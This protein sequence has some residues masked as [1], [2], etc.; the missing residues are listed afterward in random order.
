MMKVLR[1][2]PTEQQE[3]RGP[4]YFHPR[5]GRWGCPDSGSD[6]ARAIRC[7]CSRWAVASVL[8]GGGAPVA[9]RGGPG[10]CRFWFAGGFPP[11]SGGGGPPGCRLEIEGKAHLEHE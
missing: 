11:P 7:S 10:P 9:G 1:H 3:A 6:A 8:G 2:G 5:P 4:E